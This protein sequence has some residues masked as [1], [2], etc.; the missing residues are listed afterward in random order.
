M[1]T[2]LTFVFSIETVGPTSFLE[3]IQQD[4]P[5][6]V[7]DLGEYEQAKLGTGIRP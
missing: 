5:R 2:P 6:F 1:F 3:K 4:I 7:V